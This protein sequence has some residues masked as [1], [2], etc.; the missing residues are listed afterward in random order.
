PRNWARNSRPVRTGRC[1]PGIYFVGIDV[2]PAGRRILSRLRLR[3]DGFDFLR[4]H[5]R[6]TGIRADEKSFADIERVLGGR[7]ILPR[8]GSCS[9]CPG[10]TRIAAFYFGAPPRLPFPTKE[11]PPADRFLSDSTVPRQ[12]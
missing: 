3:R 4:C 12:L 7:E 2:N 6:S 9:L 11:P 1:K 5:R 8:A 10:S